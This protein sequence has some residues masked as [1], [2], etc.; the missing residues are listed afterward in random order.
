LG[1]G[2]RMVLTKYIVL[3]KKNE[4]Y[5]TIDA[6]DGIRRDIGEYFTF[7]V[8]G[9]KFMPQYR[10]RVWDGKIRLYNYASKTIYAGLYPYINKWCKDNNIQVVDGTKIK[11]VTV[12]EQAVEGFI[13]A[14][15]IPF[16]VRDYQKEAFIHAIKKS[17]SL[18]LSPTASGKSL[19]VYLIARFNLLRLRSKKNNK[20]L[21]I[22]PTTSLVE[23]LTK[24]FKDYGWDSE[25]NVHK[26]YQGHEK[27]T[28][29]RVIISTWQS[30]YNLP[31]KWFKQFGTIV[32]DEAHLFKAMS[33]TK[34]MTKLE[35]CKYRYG[36]RQFVNGLNYQEEMDFLVSHEK[37]N[38]FIVNL[39]SKLQGNT[40]CLFQYVEKHGKNLHQQ[41]KEKADDKQVFYVYGGVETEDRETIREV[42]E[43]SDN[44]IIVASFGTFSTGINIR[45]LHNIIFASPSKS[46]IRN[47]QS[48]G[49]G[50][51]LKDNKSK[52]TLY[53]I[54]DDLTYK[55]KENYTLS[56]FRERI[57]IY[58]EEEFDYEI[59][60]VDL[61]NGK[62][63][64]N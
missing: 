46:R 49:R 7:E 3:E 41:I 16:A 42:T 64:D 14:L 45:N 19:I 61:T 23:Q 44:A 21:I 32:G 27:D 47:L 15:K 12:D 38:K 55:D 40:L 2:Q 18:L 36:S 4:V 51:R 26:I 56:H 6:E 43:K 1:C 34:I 10:N 17:R 63:K 20:I 9:F 11:D 50:L 53:D 8:P 24:D 28:D 57:N 29:K 58:N 35:D 31:K 59:H 48:I 37:R 33:L 30:I 62:H 52:A 60:N 5:L 25:K 13:K 39:A 54:A 22:V